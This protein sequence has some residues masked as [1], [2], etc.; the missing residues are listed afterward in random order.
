MLHAGRRLIQLPIAVTQPLVFRASE[1]E[2]LLVDRSGRF[3]IACEA[4]CH[5]YNADNE[6]DSDISQQHRLSSVQ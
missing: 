6:T 3:V 2:R 4:H 5:G 1:S